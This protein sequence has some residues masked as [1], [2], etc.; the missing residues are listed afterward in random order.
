LIRNNHKLGQVLTLEEWYLYQTCPTGTSKTCPSGTGRVPVP[1]GQVVLVPV[2]QARCLYQ[3]CPTGTGKGQKRPVPVPWTGY[4][5]MLESCPCRRTGSIP[6]MEPVPVQP[7]PTC[8]TKWDYKAVKVSTSI[9][10]GFTFYYTSHVM[11]RFI[12]HVHRARPLNRIEIG[13]NLAE[14]LRLN[15]I[16]FSANRARPGSQKL[17][18]NGFTEWNF[19]RNKETVVLNRK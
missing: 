13:L 1:V 3:T 4:T 19:L 10:G 15:Y 7:V 9:W 17:P 12:L 8:P 14:N 6:T 11:K 5:P 16:F 18:L 2:G